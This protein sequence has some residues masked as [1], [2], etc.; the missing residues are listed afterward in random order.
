VLQTSG[1][2][3][4]VLHGNDGNDTIEADNFPGGIADHVFGDHGSD[5]ATVN[6]IDVVLGVEDSTVG[7]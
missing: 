3:G 7:A 4:C 5:T 1:D 2:G 6:D